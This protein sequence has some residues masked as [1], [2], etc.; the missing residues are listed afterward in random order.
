MNYL[1][2][3]SL[4]C[5]IFSTSCARENPNKLSHKIDALQN[6]VVSI[7]TNKIAILDIDQWLVKRLGS[8]KSFNLTN[9]DT[10]NINECFIKCV[11][12]N[13]I[14]TSFFNYRRQYVPYIDNAG[15]KKVWINCFCW[16]TYDDYNYWKKSFV[17]VD[18]GG[19]CFFNFMVD[20]TDN[21]FSDFEVNA[22]A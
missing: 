2:K 4:T 13:K 10:K 20:L 19:R 8:K 14:D 5:F 3:I 11:L 12:K 7:D 15:H 22:N 18:D 9:A 21:S 17:M 1:F 16:T 6:T